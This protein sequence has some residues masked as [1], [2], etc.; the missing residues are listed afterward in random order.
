MKINNFYWTNNEAYWLKGLIKKKYFIWGQEW[1][2]D[3]N[4]TPNLKYLVPYEIQSIYY[5]EE[6]WITFWM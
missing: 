5:D 3:Y 2:I 4:E 6:D 1:V